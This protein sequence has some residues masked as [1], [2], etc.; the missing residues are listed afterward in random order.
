M[1]HAIHFLVDASLPRATASLIHAAGQQASDVR[2][3]GLGTAD[4]QQIADHARANG[5][6]LITR[7]GDF[8]NILDYPPQ[9]YAG[10]V[11]IDAPE[12]STRDMVLNMVQQFLQQTA[13]LASLSGRLVVVEAARIRVRPPP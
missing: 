4:D 5:L 6:C 1:S 9:D 2:D 8:G 11:V 10:I 12:P 7:D 3:I 13:V